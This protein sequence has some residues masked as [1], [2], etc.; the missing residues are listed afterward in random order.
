MDPLDFPE[1]A[2]LLI[3]NHS[4]TTNIDTA[5]VAHDPG[6]WALYAGHYRVHTSAYP[7]RVLYLHSKATIDSLQAVATS[8]F[9]PGETQVVYA[10]SLDQRH[11]EHHRLFARRANGFWTTKDYLASFIKDELDTYIAKLRALAPPFYIDPR[12][13]TPSGFKRT[14]PNPLM[15][16]LVDPDPG[17]GV[18]EG[19]LGI[20][21]AE[22]G[23]GKTYMSLGLV[24]ALSQQNIIPI[25]IN[26]SQW[27]SMPREDWSSL[28]KTIIHSFRHFEAPIGWLEGQEDKFLHSCPN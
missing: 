14:R 26:S 2:D 15:S 5:A 6:N 27:L 4:R 1:I 7:F 16:L 11:R 20:L 19:M 25:Y 12:I 8:H 28:W 9:R 3:N 10:P 21:L 18:R 22:P 17:I 24:S 13:E 23:Q